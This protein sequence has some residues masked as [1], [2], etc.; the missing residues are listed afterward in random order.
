MEWKTTTQIL[1]Q[2]QTTSDDDA[3]RRLCEHFRPVV[4]HF[5]QTL[6]LSLQD[7]EDASQETL[8]TFLKALQAGHYDRDKGRL[9]AWLFGIARRV[10]LNK[11]SQ[12]SAREGLVS[13]GFWE[14]IP[15]DRTVEMTWESQWQ[16]AVLGRCMDQARHEFDPKVF[17]AFRLYALAE[18]PADQVAATLGVSKNAVY[19]A[20]S[21]VLSRLRQL[22]QDLQDLT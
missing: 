20:K 19:I 13:T 2:L 7:A 10:V 4:I 1:H 15:D 12:A 16:R 22:Q 6:G 8:M 18:V 9:G 3:W 17:E 21:R 11:R 14:A 5:A